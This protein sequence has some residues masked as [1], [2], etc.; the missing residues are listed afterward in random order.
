MSMVPGHSTVVTNELT[1]PCS[2]HGDSAP[3]EAGTFGLVCAY[4]G[5][6]A[7][8]GR[9]VTDSS[10]HHFLDL[11]LV[12]NPLAGTPDRRGGFG[13]KYVPPEPGSV[14]ADMQDYYANVV[15]WLSPPRK[16]LAACHQFG[17]SNQTD[18]FTVDDGGNLTVTWGD[19]SPGWGGPAEI[20]VGGTL[21]PGGFVA[22]SQR[23]GNPN[24]T[25][26]FSVDIS[27]HIVVASVI[28]SG[29]WKG[30]GI[31]NGPD[32]PL[33]G[34]FVPGSY[35]AV[36]NQFGVPG[37]TDVFAV[38]GSGQLT[39]SWAGQNDDWS[40]RLLM[41]P[42]FGGVPHIGEPAEPVLLPPG[43]PLAASARFGVVNQTD[44]YG[45][46][47]SGSL[48]VVSVVG[49]NLWQ[50]PQAI[51]PKSGVFPS[52]AP[53]AVSNRFGVAD[54]T[55]VFAVDLQGA[56]SV[57]SVRGTGQWSAQAPISGQGVFPPRA[58]VAASN[59]FGV[60]NQTDVFAVNN[61]GALT[62]ASVLGLGPWTG[63]TAISPAGMFQPGTAVAACNQFGTANRTDVFALNKLGQAVLSFVIGNGQWSGP[64]HLW[65]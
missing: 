38:N 32:S 62:V 8:V 34:S 24:R 30:T 42:V 18:V 41:A 57:F 45:F 49:S 33:L 19:G 27:G 44:V 10:F 39:V 13:Q 58:H 56:L 5:R 59:R 23:F 51:T 26:V 64:S 31:I 3:T 22:A 53:L 46:D 21:V 9:I 7:A 1:G 15:Q 2:F 17:I 55:D 11:N 25:D 28:Q 48:K 43:A 12:G 37:Q 47:S 50:R 61:D 63:P 20:G 6:A 36:S 16:G 54:Q 60:P 65:G 14:L 4:D 52:A 29:P 35:L 40:S